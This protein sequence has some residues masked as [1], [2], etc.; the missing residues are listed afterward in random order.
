MSSKRQMR[1]VGRGLAGATALLMLAS[2]AQAQSTSAVPL[3]RP[4]DASLDGHKLERFEANWQEKQLRGDAWANSSQVHEEL[5]VDEASSTLRFVRTMDAGPWGFYV[6]VVMDRSTLKPISLVRQ[7]REG[8]PEQVVA[9]LAQAGIAEKFEYQ[10][11]ED[12]YEAT[13]TQ[14]DGTTRTEQVELDRPVFDATALGLVLAS[15]PLEVGYEARLPIVFIQAGNGSLS[16]YDL[17]ARV[18]ADDE[19]ETEGNPIPSALR[20]ET[21]WAAP[22]TGTI[23]SPAGADESG[24]AYWISPSPQEGLPYVPRYKNNSIDYVLQ[25]GR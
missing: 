21:A 4:G 18:V 13:Y 6:T 24:G 19:V 14:F 12:G 25:A 5:T 10:F 1:I 17:I 3:I 11:S 15:L 9:Q 23:T 16:H 8:I 7:A 20:V 2:S 22:D